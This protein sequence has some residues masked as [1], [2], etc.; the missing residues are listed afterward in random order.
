MPKNVIYM[1]KRYG[2]KTTLKLSIGA[3]QISWQYIKKIIRGR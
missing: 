2:V 3:A 1:F